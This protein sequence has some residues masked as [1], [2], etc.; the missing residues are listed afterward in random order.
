MYELKLVRS[1]LKED[2]PFKIVTARNVF[3]YI[4]KNCQPKSEQWREMAWV[5]RKFK[6]DYKE[7]FLERYFLNCDD[8][9][10]EC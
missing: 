1:V 10:S 7:M 4:E 9:I 2:A 5:N 8:V 3:D 6:T